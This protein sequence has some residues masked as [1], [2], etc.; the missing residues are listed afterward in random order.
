V[1]DEQRAVREHL[2]GAQAMWADKGTAH[3]V[4]DRGSDV[5]GQVVAD[6][7]TCSGGDSAAASTSL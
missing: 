5:I 2:A 1:L 7:S 4:R 3:T 6:N